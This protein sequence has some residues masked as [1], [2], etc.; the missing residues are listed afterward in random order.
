MVVVSDRVGGDRGYMYM[1]G[2][3]EHISRLHHSLLLIL[4]DRVDTGCGRVGGV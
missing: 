1:C 3:Q 4:S 2:G